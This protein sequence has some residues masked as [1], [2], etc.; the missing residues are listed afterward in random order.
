MT[1]SPIYVKFYTLEKHSRP[2]F[3]IRKRS[4]VYLSLLWQ[5]LLDLL[6]LVR[7]F[8]NVLFLVDN[9][10]LQ[11]C[12]DCWWTHDLPIQDSA[13]FVTC[14]STTI[15]LTTILVSNVQLKPCMFASSSCEMTSR[16]GGTLGVVDI[17][18]SRLPYTLT[19]LELP[20]REGV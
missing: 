5:H 14:R 9:S 15:T 7:V 13:C 3:K 4:I 2:N 20:D 17:C 10:L 6:L 11:F 16:R 18:C 12:V 1:Y 19:P 8:F